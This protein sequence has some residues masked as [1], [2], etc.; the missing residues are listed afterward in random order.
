MSNKT[1]TTAQTGGVSRRVLRLTESAILLALATVLSLV[2][3]VDLPYGGSVTAASAVPLVLL[4]YRHG[5]GWGSLAG[6]AYGLLQL[7]FSSSLSYV[8]GFWSVTAVL[9]LDFLVAFAAVGAAGVFRRLKSQPTALM[10]GAILY[11]LLR[12]ACH[13]ISGATVWADISIPA[14]AAVLYS[15]AYNI[16]YMLPETIIAAAGAYFLGSVLN[17]RSPLPG[18]VAEQKKAGTGWLTAL[19]VGL[20]TAAVVY[21]VAAIFPYTQDAD[22]GVFTFARLG[23]VAWWPVAILTGLAVLASVAL[24]LVARRKR[25]KQAE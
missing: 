10:S 23:E 22:S 24:A 8:T 18:R 3:L 5:V 16:T 12:Y 21:D 25:K 17:F 4:A 15:L 11:G 7:A 13:V 20:V 14:D 9:V 2:K 19:S 6:L 1:Q